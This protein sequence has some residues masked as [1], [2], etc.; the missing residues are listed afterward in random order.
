VQGAG[1]VALE[2]ELVISHGNGPQVGLL[3]LQGSAY[4]EV[5]PYPLDLLGAQTEGM[6]GYLIQQELGNELP[7]EKRLASLLTLI[8]VDPTIPRS[9]NSDEADRPDLPRRRGEPGLQT[10]RGWVFQATATAFRA[11]V[12]SPLPQAD[13]W[14]RLPVEWLLRNTIASVDLR[15][16]RRHP[17]HVHRRSRRPPDGRPRRSDG[18]R[19][20]QGPREPP[21]V[22]KDLR[23]GRAV[24]SSTDV[25][26]GLRRL[27]YA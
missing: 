26:R 2:H 10:R 25:G 27:G 14:H 23:C 12:A 9:G 24:E 16:R 18:R 22:A 3:A 11:V 19:D 17:I 4:T 21:C 7:L 1:S 8:E 15:R 20:R 6:I 13:L 5:D